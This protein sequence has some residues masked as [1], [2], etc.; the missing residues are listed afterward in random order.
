L[1]LTLLG[2]AAVTVILSTCI[3]TEAEYESAEDQLL[4]QR[5]H[6]RKVSLGL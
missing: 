6:D 4:Q 3:F 2:A 1:G 5:D